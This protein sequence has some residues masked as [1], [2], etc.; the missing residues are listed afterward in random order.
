M[1]LTYILILVLSTSNSAQSGAA[2]VTQEF[3][4]ESAC[5]AAGNALVEQATKR[6]SH[7]LTWGCYVK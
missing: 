4:R 5:L 1:S 3:H 7:I 6:G 2:A